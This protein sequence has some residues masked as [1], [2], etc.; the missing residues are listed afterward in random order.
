MLGGRGPYQP[1]H[2]PPLSA[3]ETGVGVGLS[4]VVARCLAA[5]PRDRYPDGAALA[6]DLRRV[7]NN[8]P[9]R[10][11]R[12]RSLRERWRRWRRRPILA[13]GFAG[14]LVLAAAGY[15]WQHRLGEARR[16]LEGGRTQMHEGHCAAA[17][18][19]LEQGLSLAEALP[20]GGELADQ[21]R[22]ALRQAQRQQAIQDLHR[23][24]DRV[25][26]LYPFDTLPGPARL[27]LEAGCRKA[28][29]NR[30]AIR[31]RLA[32]DAAAAEA[33]REDLLDLALLG[34]QLGTASGP[35]SSR[36]EAEQVLAEA[37]A[38][39]G[40]SAALARARLHRRPGAD[41]APEPR[42]AWEHY[43]LGRVLLSDG[44]LDQ[45]ARHLDEAMRLQPEGLWPHFYAGQC[46]YRR[47][48]YDEAAAFFSVCVGAS[49]Q[50][51]AAYFNRGLAYAV[52][53]K[54]ERALHDYTRALTLDAGMGVAALNRAI[55]HLEAGR[56]DEAEADLRQALSGGADAAAVHYNQALVRQA[57][58]DR[59]GA[60]QSALEALRH[61]PDHL[62]A[63]SLRQS[64]E[65]DYPE[66]KKGQ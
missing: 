54:P 19:T 9:L 44:D 31:E 53:G 29:A 58:G 65:S 18:P 47:Q 28:W 32:V 21:M 43:A 37:E 3:C 50:L 16:L 25:R 22:D 35:T 41:P 42:T 66:A 34:T 64:L 33:V 6:A 5:E 30:G 62:Q 1:G 7:L 39:F 61:N 57:R 27:E 11:V 17:I 36:E 46:A 8:Q 52:L 55:L 14:L 20:G 60:L 45:A 48:R 23:L 56:H 13:L 51:A 40:P 4:D 63:R 49:P 10:G 26:Y 2:S 15:G 59:A 24:A 12:N 38:E